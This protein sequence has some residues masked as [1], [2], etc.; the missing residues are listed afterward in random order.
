[1]TVFKG[2]LGPEIEE[3]Q[4]MVNDTVAIAEPEPWIKS[5]RYGTLQ[6]SDK[7]ERYHQQFGSVAYVV[8]HKDRLLFE[9][10]WEHFG[11]AVPSN[12]FSMAKSIVSALTG[13]AI[14]R[15]ELEGL[16]QPLHR[17][18]PRYDTEL[19][20]K[21]T[22]RDLLTMSSGIDFDENYLNPLAFPA[23]ANYGYNLE[24]LL[25]DYEVSEEPGV[26]FDYQSGTTQVLGFAL[27]AAIR[28]SL[29]E[30]ASKNLWQKIGAEHPA[31]WS[32]DNEDGIEKSFCCFNAGARDFARLG[33]L[34]L[35]KG[36]WGDEQLLDTSYVKASVSPPGTLNSD[37]SP[38]TSYGY[39]WWLGEHAGHEVFYM[40]GI[41]GQYVL[42][43]PDLELIVTRLGHRRDYSRNKPM[44]DDVYNYLDMAFR[45][46]EDEK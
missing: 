7:E 15:G 17:L 10:Y 18:L 16:D 4:Q 39:S 40:R 42:V 28:E 33:K 5:D 14:K 20:K 27:Q 2:R 13:I 38:C 34:Y 35:Q 25:A 32:K 11:P 8:I 30:Y 19:G 26:Y 6:L 12:S 24:L 44:P 37:G 29:S 43:V 23:K 3:Y 41:L 31:F 22:I 36:R 1:M 46:I 45:M 21:V 9:R